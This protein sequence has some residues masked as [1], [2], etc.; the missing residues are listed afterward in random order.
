MLLIQYQTQFPEAYASHLR[1]F[2]F[3]LPSAFI[4][5]LTYYGLKS[6]RAFRDGIREGRS[7]TR[8]R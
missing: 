8:D 6:V 3:V 1:I 5:L 4:G 2:V 7:S